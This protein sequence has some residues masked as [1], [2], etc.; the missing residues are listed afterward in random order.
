[1][2]CRASMKT[3][4]AAAPIG[5]YGGRKLHSQLQSQLQ[6]QQQSQLTAAVFIRS[7]AVSMFLAWDGSCALAFAE[8]AERQPCESEERSRQLSRHGR[9]AKTRVGGRR[10]SFQT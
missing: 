3:E 5:L 6:S 8:A 10:P 9:A 2:G 4:R 1:M 7:K